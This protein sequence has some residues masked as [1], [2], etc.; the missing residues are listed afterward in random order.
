[1]HVFYGMLRSIFSIGAHAWRL[2][3][4]EQNE[5]LNSTVE[6]TSSSSNGWS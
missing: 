3:V 6:V 4:G 1:M 2:I 5:Q